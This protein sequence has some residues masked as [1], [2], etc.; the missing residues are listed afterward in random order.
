M[1]L[2]EIGNR[3]KSSGEMGEGVKDDR[4]FSFN[5]PSIN[6]IDL[7]MRMEDFGDENIGR[8]S[9]QLIGSMIKIEEEWN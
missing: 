6:Q 7:D 5:F 4:F 3:G 9:K 1:S 8:H 2:R